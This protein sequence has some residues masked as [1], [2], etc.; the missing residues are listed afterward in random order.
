[1]M[2]FQLAYKTFP[3][4]PNIA[5]FFAKGASL[6][7]ISE[8]ADYICSLSRLT[9]MQKQTALLLHNQ[10]TQRPPSVQRPTQKGN[11]PCC[12]TATGIKP[13]LVAHI[14]IKITRTGDPRQENGCSDQ[15]SGKRDGKRSNSSNQDGSGAGRGGTHLT[16]SGG[17]RFAAVSRGGDFRHHSNPA[18]ASPIP[19]LILRKTLTPADEPT[20]KGRAPLAAGGGTAQNASERYSGGNGSV[21]PRR[22]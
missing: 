12:Q 15:K 8:K 16:V 4:H 22:G 11:A 14:T 21:L 18:G 3:V 9:T 5:R 7:F 1:M 20:K 13:R 6:P 10:S 19:P 17:L 2:V